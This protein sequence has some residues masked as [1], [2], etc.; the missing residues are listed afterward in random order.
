[1]DAMGFISSLNRGVLAA[2]QV[3]GNKAT[4]MEWDD[5]IG[6]HSNP[7]ERTK[8]IWICYDLLFRYLEASHCSA[9]LE[10]GM[11]V[12]HV[13]CAGVSHPGP[14]VKEIKESL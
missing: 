9:T 8:H 11:L 12:P 5:A 7:C 3:F 10:C 14:K 2:F 1:M 4:V 13:Y 6:P